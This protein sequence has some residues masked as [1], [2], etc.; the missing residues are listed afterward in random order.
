[1]GDLRVAGAHFYVR[2]RPGA[3]RLGARFY[4]GDPQPIHGAIVAARERR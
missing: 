3:Y 1:M 2:V 4:G